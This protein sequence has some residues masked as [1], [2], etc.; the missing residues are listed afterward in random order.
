MKIAPHLVPDTLKD[1]ARFAGILFVGDDTGRIRDH[2]AAL[3]RA[4]AGAVSDPFRVSTLTREEHGRLRDEIGS[5]SLVGGRRVIRVQDAADG[6]AALV[7]AIAMHRADALVLADGS[8]LTG[9]SKL[10]LA[11][12]KHAAWAVIACYPETGS[13]LASEIRRAVEAAGLTLEPSALAYLTQE[14]GGDSDRRRSELEKLCLYAAGAGI[15][16]VDAAQDCCATSLDATLSAAVSAALSGQTRQCDALLADLGR[17]G[18]TGPG[19]LAVLANQVQRLLKV[20]LLMEGGQSAEEA[21]RGLFPPV[22]PRQMPG[23]MREVQRWT[24]PQ[25][26]SLGRAIREADQACKRAGSPD[27]AIAGR[28]LTTLAARS[29]R[30]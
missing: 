10:R 7:D 14:L 1:P 24:V 30:V 18:T 8:G 26:E 15:V 13:A 6:L 28:L 19:V 22:F 21:C 2:M 25:L 17:D 4:V 27:F 5:L 23:F 9:R 29:A 20:C 3:T 11:A 12:E 16:T